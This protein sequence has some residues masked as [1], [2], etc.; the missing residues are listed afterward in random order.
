M[1]PPSLQDE[2]LSRYSASGE[3]PRVKKGSYSGSATVVK[4][5]AMKDAPV[6]SF[7]S[8][9]AGKAPGV[10][11][12]SY[13]GQPGAQADISIRGF[14]SF[15]AGNAPL[16]VID[17]VPATSGDWA[18]GNMSTS[19]M[20]YL[21]PS[22]IESITVLKDAA[23][24]SLYGSR[25]SNGVILITTKK[26]KSGKL[27][28]TFKASAGFSYFAYDNYPLASDAQMEEL[29]R[30]AWYNYGERNPS[31]WKKYASLDEYAAAKVE[32]YYPSRDYDK[33]IY[34]DWEDVLF[35]T[36]IS[37]NYEYSVSGGGEK[38]KIYASVAYTDQQGVVSIDNLQRFSTTVNGETNL[39]K[40]IKIGANLQYSRQ[41]QEG[42]QEG[43]STKDNPFFIWKVVLNPRWPYAYK[44]DGSLY[45]ERWNSSYSTINP[46]ASYNAQINDAKQNRLIIKGFV[47]AKITDYLTAKTTLSSDWLYVHDRFGWLYGHPNYTA[48]SDQG[49]YM[50]DRHRNVNRTVSSTT[51]NFDKTWGDHH[52]AALA[53]WEAEEEKYHMTRIGKIDFSYAGATESIFGTNYEDGY[54]YSREEGLLSALGSLS[55]DYKA[56]YYLTGTFRR[57]GSSRLAPETRWGNFWS[58]SGSWRFSNEDFLEYEWLKEVMGWGMALRYLESD[59]EHQGQK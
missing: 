54:A 44:E 12:A 7:E 25:A 9:L 42:H 18:S 41:F 34:K 51:L 32:Q 43:A 30:Q 31:Q 47:E 20:S 11:V 14:G 8:V 33:Y 52:V 39:N 6:V 5:D 36:G 28:S 53:G 46:V 29:H 22:D 21:N 35:R 23:A 27:T 50:S 45:L 56:K 2:A 58:V 1:A 24:A 16:Y 13:S 17:G 10:Q 48:Y 26:G 3:V 55:Y 4:Q 37:Q 40:Y 59:Q 15:N 49:G 57:D 38:G 19:A